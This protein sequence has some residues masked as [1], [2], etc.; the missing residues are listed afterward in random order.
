MLHDA[1]LANLLALR[2]ASAPSRETL[3]ALANAFNVRNMPDDAK[4]ICAEL[5][6]IAPDD[7][8]A[9]WETVIAHSFGGPEELE[10]LRQRLEAVAERN[11]DAAWAWR[12]LGLLL[13]F[14]KDDDG[15]RQACARAREI[16]PR[17]AHGHEVLAYLS[18][19]VGDLDGAIEAAIHAV[20]LDPG[21]FRAL[22]WLGLCYVRLEAWEQAVRYFHRCLRVED[23]FF[24][25]V[26]SLLEVYLRAEETFAEAMQCFARI[27]SVNPRY[28]PVWFRLADTFIQRN[29]LNLAAAQAET[30]LQLGPDPTT[31]AEAWQYLGLVALMDDD[32]VAALARFERALELDPEFAAAHHYLG[33]A[34]EQ[35][36][37]LEEAE[38][39]YRKAVA[40]DSRYALPQIRL[41][42]L[43]FDRKEYENA[44]RA[45]ERARAIDEDEYMAHLGLGEIARW[46]K[47]W[48]EQLEHCQRAAELAPDDS[49]VRNQLGTA[50]DA[51]ADTDRARAEY[52]KALDLDPWNRQAANNLGFLLERLLRSEEDPDERHRLRLAAVGAWK[53]RLLACRDQRKSTRG[54]RRHL[55]ALSVEE[56]Q[57]DDWLANAT[58]AN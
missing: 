3:L 17:D 48:D 37:R 2:K 21:N 43:A 18:Y 42:Y 25:A 32:R 39:R 12:D 40:C 38:A 45:F 34:L 20:E 4:P 23:C 7:G 27:V 10:P 14:L 1:R 50:H 28:F 30:V 33:V 35:E 31:E 13:Y 16:D 54:A 11:S 51:L 58:V 55:L 41:G 15:A 8:E 49:N 57:V 5:V 26:Q 46:R 52:E 56:A 44:R 6:E 29:E 9:W 36:G 47:D 24:F 53:R 22:H 19:T